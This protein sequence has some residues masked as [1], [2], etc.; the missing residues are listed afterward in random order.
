MEDQTQATT[1]MLNGVTPLFLKDSELK[2]AN[3]G[4]RV[5]NYDILDYIEESVGKGKTHGIQRIGG[6][7]RI[8]MK[9]EE[10][11]IELRTKG[12]TVG[13]RLIRFFSE[14]PFATHSET[15][16]DKRIKV[17]IHGYPMS[18]D[19]API[20][21]FCERHKVKPV[22]PVKEGLI[23]SRGGFLTDVH[24]GSK[25][26]YVDAKSIENNPLPR[27]AYISRFRCLIYH[28][29]QKEN[30]KLCTN[31]YETTHWTRQC[32]NDR[33]C[34]VCRK[35]GH[36]EGSD[37]CEY[38]EAQVNM[39]AF[40]GYRDRLSNMYPCDF[41]HRGIPVKS[42]E[43]AFG[44]D[45]AVANGNQELADM[46]LEAKHAGEAK[47]M[48]DTITCI[49]TWDEERGAKI[50]EDINMEKYE[51]V[52]ECREELLATEGQII[53]E[54]VP[55]NRDR[56][57]GTGLDK[58]ATLNTTPAKWPGKNR[59][60]G[61]LMNVRDKLIMREVRDSTRSRVRGRTVRSPRSGS[62]KRSASPSA[63]SSPARRHKTEETSTEPTIRIANKFN[64]LKE[65]S[66]NDTRDPLDF[67]ASDWS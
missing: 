30:T 32:T 27:N 22:G 23:R 12:I 54:A 64:T 55:S 35:S 24:D 53:A 25:F 15:P 48:A 17:K 9:K 40:G 58:N 36:I 13:N 16:D 37:D 10:D 4:Q 63:T 49:D 5:K 45:K 57:W 44:Y 50:M 67:N 20:T 47:S 29:G 28:E 51:Q 6:V 33:V 62:T 19:N 1:P 42:S 21:T 14:N 52:E 59:M 8:Y 39:A 66:L 7:W 60:G 26:L 61:I 3:D 43:H 34:K 46:I 41:L 2:L 18:A 31:C 11:K 65:K 56:F 38:H